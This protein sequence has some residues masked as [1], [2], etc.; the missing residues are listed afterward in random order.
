M[1]ASSTTSQLGSDA[2]KVQI[3]NHNRVQEVVASQALVAHGGDIEA[4]ANSLMDG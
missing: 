4:A 3:N 2:F 1:V